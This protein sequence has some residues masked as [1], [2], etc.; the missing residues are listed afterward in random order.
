MG[1]NLRISNHHLKNSRITQSFSDIYGIF[2]IKYRRFQYSRLP[3]SEDE[4]METTYGNINGVESREFITET[5][6]PIHPLASTMTSHVP[7]QPKLSSKTLW[8]KNTS[9]IIVG[10]IVFV[11]DSSRGVLFPVLWS[12][13]QSLNG[14]LIDLG[15]LVATFSLGR[16][17]V[18]TPFGYLCDSYRHK[19]PL[20]LSSITLCGGAVLWANSYFTTKLSTLYISQFLLGCGSGSLGKI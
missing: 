11:G 13:C 18:T 2:E 7:N 1:S 15:Y 19:L 20:V 9:I 16:L 5:T 8:S 3:E 12:L 6:N 17:V 4:Q 10:A 14:S